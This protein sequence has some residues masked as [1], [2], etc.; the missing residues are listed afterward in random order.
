[1]EQIEIL[2]NTFFAFFHSWGD[3]FFLLV[4]FGLYFAL[5]LAIIYLLR[6]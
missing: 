4:V 5:L 6:R 3:Y 1:M 2:K